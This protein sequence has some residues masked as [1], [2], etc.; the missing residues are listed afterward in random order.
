MCC[1]IFKI[2]KITTFL[3]IT[4]CVK[5]LKYRKKKIKAMLSSLAEFLH[6]TH[7]IF[8]KILARNTKRN[9]TNSQF[10]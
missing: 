10:T 8:H 3:S 9:G 6:K 5:N 7:D 1:N 2:K 4:S